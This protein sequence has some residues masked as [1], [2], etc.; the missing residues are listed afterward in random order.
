MGYG[1]TTTPELAAYANSSMIRHTDYNDHTSDM[2]GGVLAIGE[3]VHATG[4]QVMMAI[5]LAY[6]INEA[7][8]GAGGNSAGFDAGLYYAPAVALATGKLLKLNEDQL[9]NAMSLAL[10]L[11]LPLRWT[12]RT[13]FRCRRDAP[14]RTR[15]AWPLSVRW[16]LVEGMTGPSRPFE[17][18]DGLW[19]RVTGP[20]SIATPSQC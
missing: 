16:R 9:A 2:M 12:D 6:Q 3:A 11:H 20:Y 4:T 8:G 13:P 19:D 15:F 1:I 14:R 7:L 17:G 18:R 10:S 5:I